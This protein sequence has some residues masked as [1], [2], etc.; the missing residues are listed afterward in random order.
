MQSRDSIQ[1]VWGPRTPYHGEG[2]WPARVDELTGEDPDRWVQSCCV[3]CSNG[4]ALDIG[5]KSGR[6]VGVRGRAEDRVNRGRLGP[7][8][9]HGWAANNAPDRLTRPLVRS[10]GR[11]READWPEA[12][13]L[14]VRTA[15]QVL[16]RQTA[17][18]IGIYST[19]QLFL[20][21]YYTLAVVGK[22]G[23][24]TPHM[25]GNTRLCTATAARALLETFGTDGQP[26]SYSDYDLAD[27]ILLAGHNVASQQ[28]VLWMR[29]LDR[30]SGPN[31]PKLVV[32]DPRATETARHAA[33]HLAPRVG[34]N[35]ALMNGLVHLVIESGRID[36][37]FIEGHTVGFEDLKARVSGYPPERVQ[38]I[39]GVP[40]D[41]LRE[42]AHLLGT[43]ERLM[44][45]VLQGFYQSHQAT[46]ASV[47][48]NNLQLIR[49]MIGKPGCGVL[50]MNGQPT[51]ENTRE[52]GCDGEMPGFRNWENKEHVRELARLWNVHE[53]QI[54]HWA[55]P[56]HAM[57]IF[58]HAEEGSIRFLWVIATNPAVSMPDLPRIRK[59]LGDEGL[60]LVVQDAWMTETAE[61]ADV[62]LPA[63][64]WGEKTGTFTNSDRTV[65]LSLKAVDP[66]GEAKSDLDIVLDFARRMDFRDKDGA[67]LIKWADPE[68]AFNAW[69][70][71]SRGRPCDYSG[72]TY[73]KLL[74]GSGIQWPCNEEHPEGTPR[75]YTDH[76][77]NTHAD[78][79]GTFGLDFV[80]GAAVTEEEY[81]ARDPRGRAFLKT[82]DY[83]PP[84]EEPD[85]DYP[86]WLTTGRVV[87]HFHTRTKTG[88]SKALNDAA[89]DAFVQ[90]NE[91]DARRLGVEDGD[92]VEL[93][94]RRG[95]LR[96][97]AR[98]G[99]II[100]G[101]L[102][103]PFHYGYWDEP[104]RPR[105]ANELTLPTWDP[106]SKQPH[107][108]YAAVRLSKV[109]LLEGAEDL[110]GAVVEGIKSAA[111]AARTAV[112]A[113]AKSAGQR[114]VS[115]YV[116]T[117]LQ[118]EQELAE[119]FEQVGRRHAADPEMEETCRRLA[120]WSHEHVQSLSPIL[121]RE[122][123][124]P[125]TEPPLLA[126]ALF[127]G[128]RTGGVG[129]LRDLHDLWLLAQ[130]SHV[131]WDVLHQVALGLR[132]E[133]LESICRRC[134]QNNDRQIAWLRTRIDQAAPQALIVP[135]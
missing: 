1:D 10:G 113:V 64:L 66:P 62:V 21:E 89:P 132:D 18:G 72:M 99:G 39:T 129:L 16:E 131:S 57:E 5:V 37:R 96:A 85:D 124:A 90:M 91:D 19:G 56:T 42:A 95:K 70:E 46:A 11:L 71:C 36:R 4:C 117:V 102:F 52:C 3:L 23:L 67:P 82:A 116:G 54:P 35:L 58:R 7:K 105:A 76:T 125:Q 119:A 55:A 44:S 86:F 127:R 34:T 14:V 80:T 43:A 109:G 130:E 50:Q 6:I 94:S 22:A 79:C 12:M 45:G 69:R 28:T 114:H 65:H 40:A 9:L 92:M 123:A 97:P 60:F 107:F 24:G 8:G 61:Y 59:I 29:L 81:R 98:L 15:K 48:V 118:S 78:Y 122:H 104:G 47:Q 84:P 68:G 30:L 108:K 115:D 77:F 106:A 83:I 128:R 51:A 38:E 88:R 110:A 87:Y 41:R 121:T 53:D 2:A 93:A 120:S 25:D 49:G 74:G 26:A 17:N 63:A 32:I 112:G 73:A 31:P 20:E 133:E 134:A 75:L 33:V 135:S 103:V 126:Q 111:R 13:D 100:P 27:V 101:H